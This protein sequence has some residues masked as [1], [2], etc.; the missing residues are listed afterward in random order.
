MGSA[1]KRRRLHRDGLVLCTKPSAESDYRLEGWGP[2]ALLVALE[3]E[4]SA[5]LV[6]VLEGDR[7]RW[8]EGV[9]EEGCRPG[10]YTAERAT[11]ALGPE[12]GVVVTATHP[13]VDDETGDWAGPRF[14]ASVVDAALTVA[15]VAA[16]PPQKLADMLWHE[17][18]GDG[19]RRVTELGWTL[20]PPESPPQEWHADIVTEWGDGAGERQASRGRYHHLFVKS[21]G[22]LCGTR[23]VPGFFGGE[24]D[25]S[26]S[27]W[28]VPA[29]EGFTVA[30]APM[31]VIDAEVLHRGGPTGGAWSSTRTVQFAS[32]EGWRLLHEDGRCSPRDLLRTLP[33]AAA[34]AA[35]GTASE[36]KLH[37]RGAR[38][39]PEAPQ[40]ALVDFVDA[41][42]DAHG[43]A[44]RAAVD[45]AVRDIGLGDGRRL[46]VAAAKAATEA[47]RIPGLAVYAG[48]SSVSQAAPFALSGARFYVSLT[49]SARARFHNRAPPPPAD[50]ASLLF[51]DAGA[52]GA[53]VRG[54]GWTLVPPRSDPQ[55]LHS[56]LWLPG[57]AHAAAHFPHVLWKR[58]GATVATEYAPGR[59]AKG[60][61]ADADYAR[62][63]APGTPAALLDA[64]VLH[65]GA[66]TTT[67][68]AWSET[69]SIE[70]ASA[71][72]A[73]AWRTWR[74]CG[75]VR[76]EPGDPDAAEWALLPFAS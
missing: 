29:I 74:T 67:A 68:A 4:W 66:A 25:S 65:R 55:Q 64:E 57:D 33:L 70:L 48:P 14:Y 58:G 6:E 50:V 59:F 51:G 38:G 21:G 16:A 31:I 73:D 43:A 11:A 45:E 24:H 15:S 20:V 12:A 52:A 40:C 37:E 2:Y 22:G 63:D 17:G 60:K 36:E 72:G 61:P 71:A 8:W 56:D 19:D 34:A 53:A 28:E 42:Y 18:D 54:L 41:A 69:M 5:R 62:L 44:V 32:S 3:A 27:A 7:S 1:T 76:P 75:S 23:V 47:L 26:P 30:A 35:S 9:D 10:A 13:S 49:E 46:G 39:L